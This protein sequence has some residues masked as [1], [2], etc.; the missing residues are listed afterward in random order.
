MIFQKRHVPYLQN[1]QNLFRRRLTVFM[2]GRAKAGKG[3]V[4]CCLPILIGT[5]PETEETEVTDS[6]SK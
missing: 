4:F 6:D 5:S 3:G 1:N 2:V